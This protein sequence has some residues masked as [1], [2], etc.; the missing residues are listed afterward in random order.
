MHNL[1]TINGRIAMSYLGSTPWHRLGTTMTG[2]PS[3]EQALEAANLDWQVGLEPMFLKSGKKVR[4]KQAVVRD[5]DHET[6]GIVGGQYAPLQNVDAMGVLNVACEQF[7]L[8]IETAGALGRGERC[9]ALARMP[10]S[11][12]PVQGDTVNGYALLHWGHTG[13]TPFT[14]RLTPIRV[15]CQNTLTAATKAES[16]IRLGHTS[17]DLETIDTVAQVMADL[18]AALQQTG[19]TFAALASK[20]MSLMAINAY[21]DAVLGINTE[22][23]KPVAA[24]RRDRIRELTQGG[25]GVE[26]A[27]GTAWAAFNAV[28]EYIDHERTVKAPSR[29]RAADTT[30]VFGPMMKLKAQALQLAIAA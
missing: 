22:V 9:W 24:R 11:I 17:S 30:A 12:E 5:V 6:L 23:V 19:K 3:V 7:G 29:L 8:V 26:Y 14:A 1:A 21:I 28:T 20:K 4:G 25:M 13:F 2:T 18:V 15:V 27:P 10:D 16:F